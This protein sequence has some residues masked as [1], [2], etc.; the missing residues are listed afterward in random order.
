LVEGPSKNALKRGD[1]PRQL[2]GRTMTDHIVVFDGNERLVGQTVAVRVEDA[3]A[4]TL[5]GTVVTGEQVGVSGSGRV[6]TV[7]AGISR[8]PRVSLPLV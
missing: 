5:F 1:G 3:T 8:Q 2:T 7:G 6:E 4:F